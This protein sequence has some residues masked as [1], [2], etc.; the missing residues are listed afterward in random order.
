MTDPG[1]MVQE[2][3]VCQGFNKKWDEEMY[4]IMLTANLAKYTRNEMHRNFL[5]STGEKIL[6][7]VSPYDGTWGVRIAFSDPR[8]D[9][10]DNWR[11]E[12]LLGEVLMQTRRLL[13]PHSPVPR[14]PHTASAR[15][16]STSAPK[17]SQA[18]ADEEES[19]NIP[20]TQMFTPSTD[21]QESY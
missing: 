13:Q 16:E 11:G 6:V 17:L 20:Q 14:K 3:K 8:V 1:M 12:N 18:A 15:P 2:A 4:N 7:K 5:M 10:K 9:N 19:M 21:A